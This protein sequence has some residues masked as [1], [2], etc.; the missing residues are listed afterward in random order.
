MKGGAQRLASELGIALVSP[1]TSPRGAEFPGE[2]D[3]WDFGVGAGF[4][5]DATRQPWSTWER[6]SPLLRN[7]VQRTLWVRPP[8]QIE[9]SIRSALSALAHRSMLTEPRIPVYA[10]SRTVWQ[11]LKLNVEEL[12]EAMPGAHEWQ[13][14]N[15]STVP[16]RDGDTV[17]PLSLVLSL[18]DDA[19]DRV[20]SALDALKEQLPW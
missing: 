14:W 12:P 5:L 6:A 8:I 2:S 9:P 13:L 20:E 16:E 11:A 19:D 17:D 15:Y 10:V 18:Q 1:D 3:S 4:Y 7:P